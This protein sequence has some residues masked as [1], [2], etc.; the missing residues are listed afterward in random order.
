MVR[1]HG[2][3]ETGVVLGLRSPGQLKGFL[4]F[5]FELPGRPGSLLSNKPSTDRRLIGR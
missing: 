3:F 2:L 4:W 5:K 1:T